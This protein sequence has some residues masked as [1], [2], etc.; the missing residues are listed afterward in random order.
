MK[1]KLD[2]LKERYDRK[3]KV[4]TKKKVEYDKYSLEVTRIKNLI[5]FVEN[6]QAVKPQIL[7]NQ[8][9][10]GKYIYGQTY[11]LNSPYDTKKTSYRFMIGKTSDELSREELEKRCLEIFHDKYIKTHI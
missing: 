4:L 1:S 5:D 7:Y 8:G 6:S 3:N 11:Y 2:I 10:D 9:R